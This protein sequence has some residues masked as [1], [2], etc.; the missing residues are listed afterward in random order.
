MNTVEI[1]RQD[2]HR[3]PK[4]QTYSLYTPDVYFKDPL[5]EFRS[6]NRYKLMIKFIETFF[7]RPRM[8]LQDIHQEGDCIRMRW[9]LRWRSPLPWLPQMAIPGHSE[10]QLNSEGLI[11]S[12]VDY[13]DC[14]RLDVVKQLFRVGISKEH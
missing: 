7:I 14:S 4:N 2:Y 11:Y 13:W 9:V 8:E 6:L 10:L 1:L 12:H 3:F 5:N